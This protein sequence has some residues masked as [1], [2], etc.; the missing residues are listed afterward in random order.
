SC[1]RGSFKQLKLTS[2]IKR[3]RRLRSGSAQ[4]TIMD[5]ALR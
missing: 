2:K 4:L 3:H 1:T 5:N